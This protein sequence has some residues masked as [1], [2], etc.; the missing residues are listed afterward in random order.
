MAAH[1]SRGQ[2]YA[3]NPK[4][5]DKTSESQ[6]SMLAS[7]LLDVVGQPEDFKAEEVKEDLMGYYKILEAF[8]RQIE[9]DFDENIIED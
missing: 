7:Q 9:A 3:K 8:D 5:L 6:V 4:G 2:E 1:D